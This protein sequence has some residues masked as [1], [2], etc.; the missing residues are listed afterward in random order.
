V[1]WDSAVH[2]LPQS[3]KS[4]ASQLL[5]SLQG[6]PEEKEGNVRRRKER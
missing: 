4:A 1:D 5:L 2:E 6:E 3:D